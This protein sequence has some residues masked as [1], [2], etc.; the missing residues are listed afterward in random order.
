MPT[1]R[2]REH[3]P[4]ASD[5]AAPP[6]GETATSPAVL[7]KTGR[8]RRNIRKRTAADE[9]ADSVADGAEGDGV[10][11]MRPPK[12]P[13]AGAL[14]FSTKQTGDDQMRPF[15]FASSRTVQQTTDQGAT[16]TLETETQFDRDARYVLDYSSVDT[17]AAWPF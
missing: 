4:G 13:K 9:A 10:S 2:G 17:C 7:R 12:G 16:A 6:V 15:K 5:L 14:A 1:T 3:R 8:N 11:V